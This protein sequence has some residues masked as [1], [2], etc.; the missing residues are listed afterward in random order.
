MIEKIGQ[1]ISTT[2]Q[3][4]LGSQF[5][6]LIPSAQ[7]NSFMGLRIGCLLIGIGFGLLLGLF[8]NLYIKDNFNNMP[9]LSSISSVAYGAPILLFGGLGLIISHIIESK[10]SKKDKEEE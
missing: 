8:L 7:K 5:S 1:N 2:D 9:G 4:L 6:S 3:S 10:S